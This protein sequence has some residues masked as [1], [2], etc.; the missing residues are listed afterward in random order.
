MNTFLIKSFHQE[1]KKNGA[2]GGKAKSE[3]Y[4]FISN[5]YHRHYKS[6]IINIKINNKYLYMLTMQRF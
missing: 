4:S 3:I 1:L 6:L 5:H 2:I